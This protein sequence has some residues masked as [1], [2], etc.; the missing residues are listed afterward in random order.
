MNRVQLA[1]G[2]VLWLCACERPSAPAEPE[3]PTPVAPAPAPTP[4]TLSI[5]GTNDLHGH[6]EALP[7]L[8]GYL[9]NLRHA[10]AD[11]GAVVVLDGGDM[12]QGTIASNL[13][14]GAPVVAAYRAL[15]YDAVAIG[16]HEF[17][18]GPVGPAATAKTAQDDPRGALRARIEEAGFAFLSANITTVDG[19]PAPLGL[20]STLLERAGVRIGVIGATTESTPHTTLAANVADLRF[21]PLADA[22]AREATALRGRGAAVV[23]VA[24]HAGG[25]CTAF[26]DAAALA[27]CERDE[28]IMHVADA[29]APGLVD[30]IVAGHT[31]QAMAHRVNGI[32]IIESYANG[33][34]FGR[35]DLVV[36]AGR[37]ESVTI[38]PPQRICRGGEGPAACE[39]AP[40]EGREV[41][42]DPRVAQAI[43]PA[44]TA[45]EALRAR[46]GAATHRRLRRA[47]QCR[48][49]AG[50]PL[51]RPHARRATRPRRRDR[52]RRRPAGAAARRAAALRRALRVVPV[53]QPLRD[54][55][56]DRCRAR[57]GAGHRRAPRRIVLL[58]RGTAR[59]CPLRRPAPAGDADAQRRPPCPR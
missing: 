48:V 22:I 32:A 14:E 41:A 21:T 30:V 20:P 35:V 54:R 17:D 6:I 1:A 28:E 52:Q 11:D 25:K 50:Q 15:G 38:H 46:A 18:Y 5:V 51:H 2:V 57:R 44:M 7:W 37:V 24:A 29:L 59:G 27:S 43:A 47:A 19:G 53:R 39:P 3:H 10:R 36:D 34:A 31:H 58:A 23:V 33:S 49:R 45:A 55:R 16:N 40:Y 4:I 42:P 12:F 56:D 9:A 8:G 26:E 13:E